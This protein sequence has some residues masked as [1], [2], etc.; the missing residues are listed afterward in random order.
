MEPDPL[1]LQLS[2]L[3]ERLNDKIVHVEH[4]F[5][6]HDSLVK[7]VSLMM[8]KFGTFIETWDQVLSFKVPPTTV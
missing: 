8:G 7:S 4:M 5:S 6:G 2:D 1:H 3:K